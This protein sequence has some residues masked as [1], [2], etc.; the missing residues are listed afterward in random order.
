VEAALDS[1]R[2]LAHNVVDTV[3]AIPFGF[4]SIKPSPARYAIC[5][6]IR[7][8]NELVCAEIEYQPAGYYFDV[9]SPCWAGRT[10]RDRNSSS[11]T[12][13][14]LAGYRLWGRVLAHYTHRS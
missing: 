13:C 3:G 4:V 10:S 5:D 1:F 6:R 11:Q 2:S 7:R 9:F 12:A 14:N 8:L